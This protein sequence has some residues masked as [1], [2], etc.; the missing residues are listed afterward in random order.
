[1]ISGLFFDVHDNCALL[2]Y[3]AVS[4]GNLL[5]TFLDNLLVQP[6]GTIGC[7]EMSVRSYHYSLLSNS[8]ERS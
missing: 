3:Y 8:D 5:P 4:N 2:G 6:V 1:M 7:S